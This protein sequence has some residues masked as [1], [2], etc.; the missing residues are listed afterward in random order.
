M[1]VLLCLLRLAN[2]NVLIVLERVRR[3]LQSVQMCPLVAVVCVGHCCVCLFSTRLFFAKRVFVQVEIVVNRIVCF[4]SK[5]ACVLLENT[6]PRNKLLLN[7][8]I[9]NLPFLFDC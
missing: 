1:S 4:A 2:L 6:F 7:L 3:L 8:I 5:F 9:D